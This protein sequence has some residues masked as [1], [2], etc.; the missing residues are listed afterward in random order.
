M[1]VYLEYDSAKEIILD[2]LRVNGRN[3]NRRR[4]GRVAANWACGVYSK[5]LVYAVCM[6]A[7]FAFRNQSYC[8]FAVVLRQAY[9]TAS[10]VV[11]SRNSSTLSDHHLLVGLDRGLVETR[12]CDLWHRRYCSCK[13][14]PV[15]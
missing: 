12:G 5:P 6:E 8:L 13:C 2:D 9:P 10:I 14:R 1:H 11:G 7:V 3:M 4:G 15:G